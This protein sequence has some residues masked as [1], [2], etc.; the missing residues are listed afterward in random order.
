MSS[1]SSIAA[2]NTFAGNID[3][4]D[5]HSLSGDFHGQGVNEYSTGATPLQL[6]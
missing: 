1:T 4:K 2:L 3:H 5:Q 6:R